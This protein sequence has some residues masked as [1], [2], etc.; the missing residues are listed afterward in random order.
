MPNIRRMLLKIWIIN[1]MVYHMAL[2]NG[3]H[4]DYNTWVVFHI[5]P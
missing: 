2:K 3:T 5:I 4:E 1:K